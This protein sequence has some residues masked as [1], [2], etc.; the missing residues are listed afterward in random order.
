M[1]SKSH[2]TA[3]FLVVMMVVFCL[4]C[5][6]AFAKEGS[7]AEEQALL[8]LINEARHNPLAMA[9][10][11]GMDPDQVLEDLP[12]LKDILTRGLPA[13]LFNEKLYAAASAHTEDMLSNNYFA[14]ESLDGRTYEDRIVDTGYEPLV[15]GESLGMLAFNNF[16]EPGSAVRAIFEKMFRDELDPLRTE[17]RNILDP[18]LREIGISVGS[19]P[20]N[21]GGSVWNAYLATCDFAGPFDFYAIERGLWR[22][23]NEARRFPLQAVEKAGIDEEQAREALGEIAWVLDERLPPLAWNKMLYKSALRHNRDMLDRYYYNTV[24]PDGVTTAERIKAA[25]YDEDAP[26]AG[27]SLGF[28]VFEEPRESAE[29]VKSVDP[30]DAARLIFEAMLKRELDPESGVETNIFNPDPVELGIACGRLLLDADDT[31][32]AS[33]YI[34]VVVADFARPIEPVPYIL[35]NVY[36]DLNSDYTFGL[37]EGVAGLRV[38]LGQLGA[39]KHTVVETGPLGD[40]QMECPSG[41]LELVV[42][43]DIGQVLGRYLLFEQ[44]GNRLKDIGVTIEV[45]DDEDGGT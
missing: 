22:L 8:Q 38:L 16:I 11:L 29:S 25:G 40:Y 34:Y 10:S 2:I 45:T 42:E 31:T 17:K 26:Y 41:I 32:A 5:G 30:L 14:H 9:A 13:L 6:F 35:G 44:K 18:E 24:S 21:Q 36:N 12:E 1:F 39:T 7:S 23:I 27:E 37:D 33:V 4:F 15:T 28:L 43:D 3:T 19:G 20:F